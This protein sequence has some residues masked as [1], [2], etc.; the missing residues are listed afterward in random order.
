MRLV[1][2]LLM[3]IA[4]RRDIIKTQHVAILQ[5]VVSLQSTKNPTEE[6]TLMENNV[7]GGH[8]TIFHCGKAF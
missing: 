1:I 4:E 5:T 3:E 6:D 2:C 8:A 7:T